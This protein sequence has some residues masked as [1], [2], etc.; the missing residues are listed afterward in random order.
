[1][2]GNPAAGF[3]RSG[4]QVSGFSPR[5]SDPRRSSRSLRETLDRIC[6]ALTDDH[7]VMPAALCYQIN[8][9]CKPDEDL[10]SG[11]NY[12]AGAAVVQANFETWRRSTTD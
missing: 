3:P 10:Q 1:M 11:A 2:V 8:A 12:A 5:G 6:F 9:S 4:R 7:S